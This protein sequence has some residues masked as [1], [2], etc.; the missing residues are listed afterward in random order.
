MVVVHSK[1][2]E[3]VCMRLTK[4]DDTDVDPPRR[5]T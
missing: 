4:M 1:F 3:E 5:P 2:E